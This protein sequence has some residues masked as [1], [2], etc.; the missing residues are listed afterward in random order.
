MR[1]KYF[2]KD[3]PRLER[4]EGQKSDWIDLRSRETISLEKGQFYLIP[5][6]VAIELPKGYE[7]IVAP[8]SSAFKHWGFLVVNSIGIIDESYCGD[9]DE[10]L[11]AVYATRDAVIHKYDRICQFRLFEHQPYFGFEEVETL[12]N[13]SRGGHGSTGV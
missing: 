9:E 7:A 4:I 5:L 12:G 2:D 13:K 3:Y 1:I 8:R 10:W 11:L 6:G